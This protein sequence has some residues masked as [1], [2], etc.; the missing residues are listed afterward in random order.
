MELYKELKMGHIVTI[1]W[2]WNNWGISDPF[3]PF[4]PVTTRLLVSITIIVVSLLIFKSTQE[5][6]RGEWE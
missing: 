6:G 4:P 5:M 2:G 1:L 3:C